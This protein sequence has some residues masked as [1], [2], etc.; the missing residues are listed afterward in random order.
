MTAEIKPAY[1]GEAMLVR[2]SENHNGRTVTLQLDPSLG[3]HHPFKG[4]RGGLN[5]QRMQLAAVL[6]G[7]DEQPIAPKTSTDDSGPQRSGSLLAESETPTATKGEGVVDK[8]ARHFRDMP[9]SQQCALKCE[10]PSFQG[11]L[12][13][14]PHNVE[15]RHHLGNDDHARAIILELLGITS[16]KE[17]DTIP[18]KAVLWDK[19]LTDY[20]VRGLAR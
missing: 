16:R 7:D 11:W 19:L 18:S 15:R 4:L 17:L 14:Q 20:S 6:I 1:A 5:G 12:Y 3:E 10:D 2:W 8:P 9:R 13:G